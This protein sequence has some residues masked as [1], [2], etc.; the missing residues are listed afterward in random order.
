MTEPRRLLC[1]NPN[2]SIDRTL[3]V[4][5]FRHGAVWRAQRVL[6]V[7][8][9]KG[10]NV[11]R[12]AQRLGRRAMCCGFLAGPTGRVAAALAEREGLAAHWTWVEGDSRT[13]VMIVDTDGGGDGGGDGG[14]ATVINEPGPPVTAA[15]WQHLAGDVTEQA[16]HAGTVCLCG[17]LPPGVPA[18]G[19][20]GLIRDLG[21]A[22]VPVWVDTSGAALAEAADSAPAGLKVN[23]A[24]VGHLLGR[25]VPDEP[26]G[27]AQVASALRRRGPDTPHTVVVT[28]GAAGAVLVD[29]AGAWAVRPPAITAVSAV[30]SGDAFLAGLVGGLLDG[31]ATPEAL[32]HAAACGAANALQVGGGQVEPADVA[33][34]ERATVVEA[35]AA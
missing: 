21:M 24:E 32:R 20:A 26:R 15:G 35:M 7:C 22:G 10:L 19:F 31:L 1:V 17:S 34:L 30:G 12:V 2:V 4:P 5:G 8:G 3:V 25:P 29:G 6:A 9:G 14:E 18:G 16:A 28:L 11:A 27:A 33:R 23:A 13:C